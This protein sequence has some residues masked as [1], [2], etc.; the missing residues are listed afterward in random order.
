[1]RFLAITETLAATERIQGSAFLR[2]L[3]A[4]TLALYPP[5]NPPLPWVGYLAEEDGQLV[6]TCAFK[7]APGPDGVEIAYFT[8]PE[9]ERR[10]VATQMASRLVAIAEA[11]DVTLITAETLPQPGASTRIL[12]KLGFRRMGSYTHPDDGEVWIWQYT[13]AADPAHRSREGTPDQD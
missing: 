2:S 12:E 3:C 6:G 5:G 8:F 11:H 7:S 4:D 10:G 13:P 9:H 1:M